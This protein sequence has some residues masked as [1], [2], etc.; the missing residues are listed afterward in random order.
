MDFLFT[1]NSLVMR[2]AEKDLPMRQGAESSRT[3]QSATIT[4]VCFPA[5]T[6]W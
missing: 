6:D 4:L 3:I 2:A 1:E 5:V